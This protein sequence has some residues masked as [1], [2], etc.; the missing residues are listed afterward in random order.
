MVE[1]GDRY[2]IRPGG[3]EI[4]AQIEAYGPVAIVRRE[5]FS[6]ARSRV[7]EYQASPD[8]NS[9]R[10]VNTCSMAFRSSGE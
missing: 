1:V 10:P 9:R 6:S 4:L 3:Q 5:V 2:I 7:T 8:P